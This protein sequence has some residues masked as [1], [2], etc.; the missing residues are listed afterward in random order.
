M[1]ELLAYKESLYKIKDYSEF[2]SPGRAPNPRK[3]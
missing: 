2:R 3:Y 1:E